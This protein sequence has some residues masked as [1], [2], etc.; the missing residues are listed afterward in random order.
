VPSGKEENSNV[1][2][3]GQALNLSTYFELG[4][5]GRIHGRERGDSNSHLAEGGGMEDCFSEGGVL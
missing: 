3:C 1:I 5:A 4:R 2:L